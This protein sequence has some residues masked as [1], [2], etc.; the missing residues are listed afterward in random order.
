MKFELPNKLF[1]QISCYRLNN[2]F[3]YNLSTFYSCH[4]IF[5]T[6]SKNNLNHKIAHY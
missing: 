4:K 2:Y 5:D 1:N 6:I 3:F